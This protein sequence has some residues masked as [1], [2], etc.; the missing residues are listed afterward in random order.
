MKVSSMAPLQRMMYVVAPRR[1]RGGSRGR[2]SPVY[3]WGKRDLRCLN[4]SYVR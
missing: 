3:V 4:A 2:K 1:K